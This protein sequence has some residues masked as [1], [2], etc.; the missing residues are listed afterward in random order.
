MATEQVRRLAGL[1][2]GVNELKEHV[3]RIWRKSRPKLMQ[4]YD[5][6][7]QT[8]KRTREAARFWLET[9]EDLEQ[10]GLPYDQAYNFAMSEWVCLPDIEEGDEEQIA[11]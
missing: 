9:T 1:R 5:E 7:A 6:T 3:E 11:S 4:Y 8:E 2:G 10:H